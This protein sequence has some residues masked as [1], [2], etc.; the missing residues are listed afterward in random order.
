MKQHYG[1]IAITDIGP[2]EISKQVITAGAY[3]LSTLSNIPYVR[4]LGSTGAQKLFSWNERVVIPDGET[5][6]VQNAS[7]HRGDIFINGGFDYASLPARVTV[8]VTLTRTIGIATGLTVITPAW[9]VDTRRARKAFLVIAEPLPTTIPN[10][11]AAVVIGRVINHSCE[12]FN[13][14]PSLSAIIPLIGD[15]PGI[16]FFNVVPLPPAVQTS[17]IP[18]GYGAALTDP[19][20]PHALLDCGIAIIVSDDVET[21]WSLIPLTGFYVLEY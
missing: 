10:G 5:A 16:G 11:A 14:I 3:S 21:S 7:C 18:L 9:P 2:E 13:E 1:T 12:T 19:M 6:R 4:L 15:Q 20:F 17:F 8:P